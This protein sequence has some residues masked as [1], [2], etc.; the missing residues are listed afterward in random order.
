[1]IPDDLNADFGEV[2]ETDPLEFD[3]L[4]DI[5]ADLQKIE[6]E[7]EKNRSKEAA[8]KKEAGSVEVRILIDVSE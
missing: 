8:D 1:M 6:E 4:E 7:E 5:W 2:E 3:E